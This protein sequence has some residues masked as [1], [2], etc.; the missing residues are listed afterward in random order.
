MTNLGSVTANRIAKAYRLADLIDTHLSEPSDVEAFEEC[1]WKALAAADGSHVPSDETRALVISI[2]R[3]RAATRSPCE[4]ASPTVSK[5]LRRAS[6]PPRRN[7]MPAGAVTQLRR[8]RGSRRHP[9]RLAE[10][11]IPQE[12]EPMNQPTNPVVRSLD[13]AKARFAYEAIELAERAISALYQQRES[14]LAYH[15]RPADRLDEVLLQ[16]LTA[17]AAAALTLGIEFPELALEA[18]R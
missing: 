15:H 6:P 8:G 4:V 13:L 12:E 1:H 10:I 7:E 16:A 18:L 9:A 17:N 2:L 3:D 11:P 14:T 5:G